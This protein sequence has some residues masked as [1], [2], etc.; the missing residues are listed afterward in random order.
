M[1]VLQQV[2]AYFG[3]YESQSLSMRM[4]HCGFHE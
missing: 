3:A 1:G 2:P 4:Y